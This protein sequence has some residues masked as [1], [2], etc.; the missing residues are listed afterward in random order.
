MKLGKLA[1][2]IAARVAETRRRALLGASERALAAHPHQQAAR[3][4]HAGDLTL[5]QV[6]AHS[7]T[8]RAR[9]AGSLRAQTRW[10][11]A[12]VDA[13]LCSPLRPRR[14]PALPA[15]DGWLRTSPRSLN[16]SKLEKST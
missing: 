13:V 6:V 2:W 9:S 8:G 16:E 1:E 7:Q 11:L 5:T 10:R 4:V 14:S 12:L 3:A 15:S